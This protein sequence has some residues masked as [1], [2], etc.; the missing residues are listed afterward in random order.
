MSVSN[1]D[2]TQWYSAG[3]RA[4]GVLCIIFFVLSLVLGYLP[5]RLTHF[6]LKNVFYPQ[7]P[8]FLRG[9]SSITRFEMLLFVL[10]LASN[11]LSVVIGFKDSSIMKRMGLMSVI[12]LVPLALGG[13]MNFIASR[14]KIRPQ[15]YERIHRWVAKVAIVEGLLHSSMAVASRSW[16]LPTIVAA[17]TLTTILISSGT[18]IRRHFYEVFLKL[19]LLLAGLLVTA[20]WLHIKPGKVLAV[21]KVYLLTATCLW[22]SAQLLRLGNVLYRNVQYHNFLHCNFLRRKL[23]RTKLPRTIQTGNARVMAIAG[24]VH[25]CVKLERPWDFRAGQFVYLTMPGLSPSA[26]S[27]SHPAVVAWWYKSGSKK[28]YAGRPDTIVF[29]VQPRDGISEGSFTGG[30]KR[31]A[32]SPWHKA[33]GETDNTNQVNGCLCTTI[34]NPINVRAIVEGPYGEE[35]ELGSYGTVLLFATGIGIAA[36]VAYARRF[37]EKNLQRDSKVQRIALFWEVESERG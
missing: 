21:P 3:L 5:I 32:R 2:P 11:V 9:S 34:R 29:I 22:L 37:L 30:L 24:A 13:R 25:I 16:S 7:I 4:I 23:P 31:V 15:T 33:L 6:F 19:H 1:M 17:A 35:L 20:V 18:F 26:F 8:Q 12:N 14:C 27:Q 28:H 10:F 36:Q